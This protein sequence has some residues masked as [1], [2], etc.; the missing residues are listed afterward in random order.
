MNSPEILPICILFS[1][2]STACS[3]VHY[4]SSSLL[5]D[6]VHYTRF[7]LAM[8]IIDPWYFAMVSVYEIGKHNRFQMLMSLHYESILT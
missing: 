8:L 7:M 2:Y 4:L 3:L 1:A 6:I 5:L